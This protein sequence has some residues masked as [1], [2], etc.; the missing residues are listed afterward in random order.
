SGRI[1][2]R[3]ARSCA[4]WTTA[5]TWARPRVCR[6]VASRGSASTASVRGTRRRGS[7]MPAPWARAAVVSCGRGLVWP[8]PR[9]AVAE[10][11]G[12]RTRLTRIPD[13]AG[14]EDR[15]GHQPPERLHQELQPPERLH[16]EP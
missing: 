10:A 4:P 7:S 14:F 15:E 1:S 5:L 16:Q 12:N 6:A 8:W 2:P 3:R 9:V 13:H 11:D